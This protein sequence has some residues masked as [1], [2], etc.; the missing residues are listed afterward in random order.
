LKLRFTKRATAEIAAALEWAAAR[1]PQTP[2]GMPT[3]QGGATQLF[4]M[5][6]LAFG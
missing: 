4:S 6:T 3:G 2:P 1:S 5:K